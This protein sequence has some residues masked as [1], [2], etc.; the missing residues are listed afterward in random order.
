LLADSNVLVIDVRAD[1][2]WKVSDKKI[3]GAVRQDPKEVKGMGLQVVQ[4]QKNLSLLSLSQ[5]RHKRPGGAGINGNGF[6]PGHGSQ[7]RME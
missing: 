5:R 6:S 7:R 3:K 4:G 1:Q 2:D